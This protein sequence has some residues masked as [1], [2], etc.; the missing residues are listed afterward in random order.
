M[1]LSRRLALQVVQTCNVVIQKP[2][3]LPGVLPKGEAVDDIVLL[4]VMKPCPS[5]WHPNP[6]PELCHSLC[7]F[8]FCEM[9]KNN[10]KER[11]GE[12]NVYM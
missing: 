5:L 9:I 6:L 12:I 3:I 7:T 8:Y 2:F 11:D 1:V 10:Y 4:S